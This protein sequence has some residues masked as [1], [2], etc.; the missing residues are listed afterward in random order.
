MVAQEKKN[1]DEL[2][3][4]I[5]PSDL[6]VTLMRHYHPLTLD[7]VASSIPGARVFFSIL[8]AKSAFWHMKLDEQSS[9]YTT[10]NSMFRQYRYHLMPHGIS[11]GSEVYH[12]AIESFMEGTLCK[13]IADDILV[14]STSMADYNKSLKIVL[15]RPHKINPCL[16]VNKCK[17]QIVEV[18]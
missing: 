13:V 5:D 11:S 16:N 10:F 14:Y 17:F 15:K 2:R 6:N 1:I 9:Y 3:I 7:K 4:C 8:D 12:Q 18:K